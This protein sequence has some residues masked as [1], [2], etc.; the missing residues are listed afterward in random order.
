[1]VAP[2]NKKVSLVWVTAVIAKDA[3]T[4]AGEYHKGDIV[5]HCHGLM[6]VADAEK[7]VAQTNQKGADMAQFWYSTG[8]TA[9]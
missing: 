4:L 6:S 3:D 8:A 5:R 7:L 2:P 1:M 9:R